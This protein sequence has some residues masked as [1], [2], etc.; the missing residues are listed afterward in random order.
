[1]YEQLLDFLINPFLGLYRVDFFPHPLCEVLFIILYIPLLFLFF[2]LLLLFPALLL[3]NL[4]R[5][6]ARALS[7]C[8]PPA[9]I[10]VAHSPCTKL[11]ART[12]GYLALWRRSTFALH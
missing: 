5:A 3:G 6:R 7:L 12:R 11:S 4:F 8:S 10:A 1:M 2:L 9:C